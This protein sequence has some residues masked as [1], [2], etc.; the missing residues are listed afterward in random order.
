M[1]FFNTCFISSVYSQLL[2]EE[3]FN[4]T[5]GDTLTTHGWNAYSGA[6][7]NSILVSSGS[8]SFTNYPSSGVGNSANIIGTSVS[9]EDD[10]KIFSAQTSGSIYASVLVNFSSATT[11]ADGDYFFGFFTSTG[12]TARGRIFIKKSGSNIAFGVSKGSTIPNLSAFSYSLNTTYLLVLKYK[13]NPSSSDDS[14][15]L[16][17]NPN[18]SGPE[19]ASNLTNV[20]TAT[21]LTNIGAVFLRQ[22]VHSY[23][24]IIDG[25]R[26]ATSWSQAPLP[27]ELTSFTANVI[28][29]SVVLNWQTATEVNNY[30]FEIERAASSTMPRQDRWEKIGF[31]NGNGN[32]NSPKSYSFTDNNAISGKYSYRLKQIDVDGKFEYSEV[33]KVTVGAPAKFELL[34]NYPNPF[35]PTTK[36]SFALPVAAKV[37]LSVF[38]ML[39]QK[40]AELAN[41]N[42]KAGVHSVRFNAT[43]YSSGIYFYQLTTGKFIKIKKMMLLK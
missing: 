28:D 42:F 1:F 32:S 41:H 30:G 11:A 18:L 16:F 17:I 35:N 4:Y 10:E 20:D 27:V 26:V 5:A 24:L 25:I 38:N 15:S 7:N 39:G 6:G 3:N 34:Q 12:S 9:S 2:L 36:I 31:V 8:L 13:F 33:A 23:S 40:V 14:I 29:N 43:N 37:N 22:G 19:P 21:D